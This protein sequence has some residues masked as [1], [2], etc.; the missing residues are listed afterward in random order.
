M[1]NFEINEELCIQ[2]GLCVQ[3]CVFAA[4]EMDDYPKMVNESRCIKC[5]HCLAVCPTGA[6]SIIGNSP[7]DSSPIKGNIPSEDQM[8]ILIKGR[9]SVRK[10][11]PEPLDPKVIQKLM[12]TAWHAPTGVNSQCVHVT[13]MEDPDHVKS[14]SDEIHSRIEDGVKN[15][16]L[17]N[18]P[19]SHYF[20]WALKARESGVDMLFRGAPHLMIVSAP[21]TAPCPV[22]DTHIF[23]SYFE[24]MAQSMKI[25]TLW[26]GILKAT[27]ESIF[28]DLREKL[29]IP[30]DHEIGYA[31]IF[32][33]PAIQYQRTIER[34]AANINRVGWNS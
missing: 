4:I 20:E 32:G 28:P 17:L 16:T 14:F 26:N 1:I 5:Q 25:G 10:Y 11:K 31:M 3:D 23:L 15:G 7:E 19:I 18:T 13:L 34:G 8:S 12:D 27:V 21:K 9:R 22:A 29:G 2:C 30:E 6:L 24:L 33:K